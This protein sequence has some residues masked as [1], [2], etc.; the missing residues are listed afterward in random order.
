MAPV[1]DAKRQNASTVHHRPWIA[2]VHELGIVVVAEALGF[3]AKGRS[4]APCP[5]CGSDQRG[6]SNPD[7]RG[8]V[9][10]TADGRGFHCHRCQAHGDA[11]VFAALAVVGVEKP[12][13]EQWSALRDACARAGLCEW[14]G[15]WGRDA[16][17]A[18]TRPRPL[19]PATRPPVRP[20]CET[21][22]S[23]WSCSRP[24]TCDEAVTAWLRSR[25]IEP[26]RVEDLELA[27]GLPPD[28]A[29]PEWAR[30]GDGLWT[31]TGHRLLLPLYD[32]RGRMASLH[33]RAIVRA[34]PKS[35]SPAGCALRG[36]VMA[37]AG[38]V[39]MLE[40]GG[41]QPRQVWIA[42]GVPD[43]LTLA[44]DFNESDDDSAALGVV[45]GSW[46]AKIAARV[47]DACRVVI[48][49]HGD[50]KGDQ[51]A[52]RI[53]AEL[54]SRVRLSRWRVRTRQVLQ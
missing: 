22:A 18:S 20:A 47:P 24:V 25:G 29:L 14:E 46:T 40:G 52:A 35:L 31:E 49:T 15:D 17:S 10:V 54:G 4:L 11:V 44:C 51:Y 36:L 27:R 13:R 43:F 9:G 16:V 5:A 7:K 33:A 26:R 12:A 21:V 37:D 39:R 30:S 41:W 3:T 53:A 23:L 28:A 32:E 48:A 2:G 1:S 6:Y 34:H 50:E 8:P 38:G 19:A 45:S 42:E